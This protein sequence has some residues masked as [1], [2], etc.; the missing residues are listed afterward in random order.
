MSQ[1]T[2]AGANGST[3]PQVGSQGGAKIE[4]P[5]CKEVISITQALGAEIEQKFEREF[6]ERAAR[7]QAALEAR[8]AQ[9]RREN[10][11]K[12]ALEKQKV[13]EELTNKARIE[14]EDLKAQVNEKNQ[15]LEEAQK[16]ELE[17][18]KK[19]R[20]LEDKEKSVDLVVQRK[21]D[22]EKVRLSQEVAAKASE[23]FR[24]K[25]AEKDHQLDG[26]RKQIE[27]LKRKSEQGSQQIQGEVLELELESLLRS[28]FPSDQI[29]PVAKGQKGGDIV[30]RVMTPS[31]QVAGTV[32]WETKRTKNWSDGWIDKLKDD[33][34]EITAEC[35]VIVSAVLPK[36]VTRMAQVDGVWVCELGTVTGLAAAL[37]STLLQVYLARAAAVG[38]GESADKIYQYMTGTQFKQRVEAIFETFQS[39]QTDLLK[40]KTAI[41]KA[42]AVREKQLAM[43]LNQTVS[44]Y[45]D[46]QGM[47]GSSLPKIAALELDWDESSGEKESPTYV[48]STA[49]GIAQP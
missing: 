19:Q 12:L 41:Q 40:E 2:F 35:A 28:T 27:D 32:L 43:I 38:K 30:Q 7:A 17:F 6:K 48:P 42:W 24:Q 18:R 8:L 29:E 26:M 37:R 1:L 23:E 20:E 46:I 25:V 11:A 9:E 3:N 33:Q 47:I 22:E 10:E 36:G 34:R 45:G 16:K 14:F 39:M 4:C 13:R 21:L 44:M 15:R 31:G 5:K 49:Q